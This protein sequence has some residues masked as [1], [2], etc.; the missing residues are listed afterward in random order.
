M[1][2]AL[3]EVEVRD[4]ELVPMMQPVAVL[5]LLATRGFPPSR[6]KPVPAVR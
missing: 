2:E 4:M 5:R 1:S 3:S 6:R